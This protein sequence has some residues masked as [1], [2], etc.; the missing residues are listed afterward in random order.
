M[1]KVKK[2]KIS[3]TN[4]H[5]LSVSYLTDELHKKQ[6]FPDKCFADRS[7]KICE[8]LKQED[9][10]LILIHTYKYMLYFISK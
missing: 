1:L 9:K 5:Y 2:I 4:P 8:K 10:I 3:Q 7:F 6:T